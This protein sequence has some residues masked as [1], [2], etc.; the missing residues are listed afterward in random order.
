MQGIEPWAVG[1]EVSKLSIVL[2][3]PTPF[4][5]TLHFDESVSVEFNSIEKLS[6][7]NADVNIIG[8]ILVCFD[9]EPLLMIDSQNCK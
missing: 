5:C 2:Y 9:D 4:V 3:V 6:S 7:L 8:F 1:R